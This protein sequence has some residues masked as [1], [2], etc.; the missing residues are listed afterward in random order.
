MN[1]D[2]YT[3]RAEK[4]SAELHLP[5]YPAYKPSG[6]DW[7][8]DVPAHWEV[9]R[10]RQILLLAV[11]EELRRMRFLNGVP[12]I[13]YGDLYTSQQVSHSRQP[14]M[15]VHIGKPTLRAQLHATTIRRQTNSLLPVISC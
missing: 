8:G 2:N 13:R 5:P 1:S 4:A 11:E 12:C 15:R 7:L 9:R 10:R 3:R 6:V 14:L